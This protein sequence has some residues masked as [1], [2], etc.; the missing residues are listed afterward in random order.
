MQM[1]VTIRGQAGARLSFIRKLYRTS[2]DQER[3]MPE[4]GI[5]PIR[6]FMYVRDAPP[7]TNSAIPNM[8]TTI[9]RPDIAIAPEID[10][11]LLWTVILLTRKHWQ[12]ETPA[13]PGCT[14]CT[15]IYLNSMGA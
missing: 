5:W 8:S 9:D 14:P 6:I 1:A 7:A 15:E 2:V 4:E 10:A 12:A 13:P 3:G 11:R